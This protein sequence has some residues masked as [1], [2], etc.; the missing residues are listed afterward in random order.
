MG[1]MLN[2]NNVVFLDLIKFDGIVVIRD[3][4]MV[5]RL[6]CNCKFVLEGILF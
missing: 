2:M 3:L 4:L 6:M 5:V 1:G